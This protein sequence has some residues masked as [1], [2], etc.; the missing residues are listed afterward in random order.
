[1][2]LITILFIVDIM[3]YV[4]WKLS[5]FPPHRVI[6]TGT[7]LQTARFRQLLAERL[8]IWPKNVH[9][10]IIGEQGSNSS[11]Y[12]IEKTIIIIIIYLYTSYNLFDL[13][14]G[15]PHFR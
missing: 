14:I 8:G 2:I 15:F 4:A 13:F 1:M 3:T 5:G 6:G 11:K 9:A 10:Y 7:V 12:R